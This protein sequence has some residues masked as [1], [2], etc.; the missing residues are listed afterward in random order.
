MVLND[1]LH[2]FL[3][4]KEN[5]EVTAENLT[6]SFISNVQFFKNYGKNL[7]GLTGTLG[8]QEEQ[9][10]LKEIYDIEISYI[11]T[12]KLKRIIEY[13]LLIK[14]NNDHW[15]DSIAN[16]AISEYNK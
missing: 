7:Y 13:P 11:P 16:S 10:T 8:S 5:L 14:P 6:A 1:G 3:Q 4:I 9:N 2:Q 12:F 15:T